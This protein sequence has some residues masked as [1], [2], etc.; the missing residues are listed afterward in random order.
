MYELRFVDINGET[1]LKYFSADGDIWYPEHTFGVPRSTESINQM[2]KEAKR[3]RQTI[4]IV[5]IDHGVR[6]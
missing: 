6:K 1:L 4:F 2:I 3:T 5:L